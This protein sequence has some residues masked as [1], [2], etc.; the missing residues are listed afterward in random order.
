MASL[1]D[2]PTTSC[3]PGRD[4]AGQSGAASGVFVLALNLEDESRPA[5]MVDRSPT[6][7]LAQ[8]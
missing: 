8:R 4:S 2:V 3:R 6:T 5:R 1:A 7:V